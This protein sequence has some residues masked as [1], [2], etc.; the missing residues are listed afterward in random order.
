MHAS[1]AVTT[2]GLP[3]GLTAVKFRTRA[4][5]KGTNAL[6]RRVNP[7]RVPIEAK[8]SVRWP[9]DM[10]QAAALLG[11]PARLVHAGDRENDIYELFR[12]ARAAGTHLLVRT[13]VDRLAGDGR[14]TIADGMG[15]VA[16]AS[17]GWLEL[18][19]A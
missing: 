16:V 7:T 17:R 4:K 2:D 15:E 5:S 18:G 10:R 11:G 14:H 19:V 1:L 12:A 8:E 9:E 3:L 6:K 13:C